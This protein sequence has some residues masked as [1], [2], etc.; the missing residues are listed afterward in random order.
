MPKKKDLQK[1]PEAAPSLHEQMM[2]LAIESARS[3]LHVG[4]VP[5]GAVLA[6]EDSVIARGF[7]QPIRGVDPTAHAE[8]IAL[9]LAAETVGNYRLAGTTLYV[10]AEPCLMCV[11]A[12]LQARVSTL[13]FGAPEPKFGAVRS[14]LD[15]GSLPLTHRFEVVSGVLEEECRKLLQDFFKFKREGG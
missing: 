9:R 7:N 2:Q 8:V 12:A 6:R 13:V 10:T 5:I 4:E 15:V 1:S 11:G 14:I 3:A